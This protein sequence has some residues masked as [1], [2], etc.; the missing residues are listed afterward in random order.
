MICL[1][2]PQPPKQKKGR[3]IKSLI[4]RLQKYITPTFALSEM[5][6]VLDQ[7]YFVIPPDWQNCWTQSIRVS[8]DFNLLF[9]TTYFVIQLIRVSS[10]FNL[11]FVSLQH[12]GA[13]G[14][15]CYKSPERK[16]TN[17]PTDKQIKK[18][19]GYY[20]LFIASYY[21]GNKSSKTKIKKKDIVWFLCL[22]AYQ[23][24]WTY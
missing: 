7:V 3:I 24:S 8:S 5:T 4:Y 20:L 16:Q 10:D 11:L 21:L 12:L 9:D 23:L 18:C 17:I 2:A 22:I 19:Q 14:L 15:Q 1:L 13:V 6:Q